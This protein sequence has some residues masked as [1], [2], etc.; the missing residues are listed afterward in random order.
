MA[1]QFI[2]GLLAPSEIEGRQADI[3]HKRS[4]V[5]ME[6]AKRTDSAIDSVIQS[7]AK[8][9]DAYQKGM[10]GNITK[11]Q[12]QQGISQFLNTG[13]RTSQLAIQ[14][15]RNIQNT[16]ELV[17]TRLSSLMNVPDPSE[18]AV[19][20]GSVESTQRGAR[21][22]V[23]AK[24]GIPV[25]EAEI[26]AGLRPKP[27]ERVSVSV[28]MGE[29][30]FVKE[31]GKKAADNILK[32]REDALTARKSIDTIASARK[33]LNEGMTSGSFA[34]FRV[35][36]GKAAR[37]LGVSTGDN[38]IDNA[39]AFYSLMAKETANI[40]KSFGAGTG[41]SDADRE[42]ALRAAGG[43]IQ[44][45]EESIRKVLDI[46]ERAARNSIKFHNQQVKGIKTKALEKLPVSLMV[47]E[48]TQ[49][50]QAQGIP[51]GWSIKVVK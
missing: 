50:Q 36:L 4:V 11:E 7:A 15:G 40:I 26:A 17:Q 48:P 47:D 12:Y 28:N 30:A 20:L 27:S 29:D 5:E 46:N 18:T 45:T 19:S 34:N 22:D 21:A 32:S 39:Q 38:D 13:L 37:L 35:G 24:R 51:K 42:Y 8:F 9:S 10:L 49:E 25:A 44:M 6:Q 1:S 14:S 41:L 16:P 23:A 2:Q 31:A 43:D 33:I 3:Q